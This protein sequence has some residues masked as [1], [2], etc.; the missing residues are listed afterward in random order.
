MSFV[1]LALTRVLSKKRLYHA[2]AKHGSVV[3]PNDVGM[4]LRLL[5]LQTGDHLEQGFV[6][7]VA[8]QG[9]RN[10]CAQQTPFLL[11][12]HDHK[13]MATVAKSVL[14]FTELFDKIKTIHHSHFFSMHQV[15]RTHHLLPGLSGN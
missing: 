9:G 12:Q 5:V 15:L 4:K 7:I 6:Q 13:H 1:F 2:K 14:I 8:Y 11:F 3:G 10:P